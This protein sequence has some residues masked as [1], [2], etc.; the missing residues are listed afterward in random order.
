MVI[1]IELARAMSPVMT[2]SLICFPR[3]AVRARETSPF[4]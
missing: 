2:V 1:S 3:L 4:S